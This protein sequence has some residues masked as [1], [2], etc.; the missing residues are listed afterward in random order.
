[1]DLRRI[2][3]SPGLLDEDYVS[4]DE[5]LNGLTENRTLK[6]LLSAIQHVLR[7]EARGDLLR[8]SQQGGLR[9]V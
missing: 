2:S 9:T 6:G 8:Q 5:V 7:G 3:L 4:L 1:M